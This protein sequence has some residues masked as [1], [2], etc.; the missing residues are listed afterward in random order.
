MSSC[1]TCGNPVGDTAG[2]CDRC[3]SLPTQMSFSPIGVEREVDPVRP[4]DILEG[5][6][7]IES[8]L[9]Q[10]GMGTVMR[11]HDV[12]LNRTVAVKLLAGHLCLQEDARERFV[13]EAQLTAKLE[14]PNIVSI[15]AVGSH[16]ERPFF[17]MK[18]LEGMPLSLYLRESLFPLPWEELRSMVQQLCAGLEFIHSKGLVHRDLK[19]A[20]IFIGPTGHLTILDFGLLHGTEIASLTQVGTVIGTPTYM[21][22]EQLSNQAIDHRADLFALS[23]VVFELLFG[24]TPFGSTA[25]M[26]DA[27]ASRKEVRLSRA[28]LS[29]WAPESAEAYFRRAL[30]LEKEKRFQSAREFRETFEALWAPSPAAAS[31]RGLRKRWIWGGAAAAAGAVAALSFVSWPEQERPPAVVIDNPALSVAPPTLPPATDLTPEPKPPSVSRPRF[32]SSAAL[33]KLSVVTLNL[34]SPTWANVS[35]DGKSRGGTPLQ[36]ELP[37]G[38]H[39]LHVSRKG[40]KTIDRDIYLVPGSS[41]NVRISLAP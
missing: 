11:A 8:L 33:A 7:R 26:L 17:V 12:A 22:P 41:E 40:F 6:W 10:G 35:I 28:Q 25:N 27:A 19:P 9:G 2:V 20:N 13:R 29:P 37:A 18:H 31:P 23:A 15:Y 32:A 5:K 1:P 34:N 3:S 4:G 38:K 36:I 24:R 14:H 30:A 21:A 39:R 16:K